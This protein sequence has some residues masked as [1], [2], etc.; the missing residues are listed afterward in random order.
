MQ[1]GTVAGGIFILYHIGRAIFS[2]DKSGGTSQKLLCDGTE[3]TYPGNQY[4]IAA[5]AIEAAIWGTWYLPSWTENDETIG[6]ILMQMQTTD[7]VCALNNAFGTRFRGVIFKDGGNLAQ[8]LQAYLDKSVKNKVNEYYYSRGIQ[9]F[10][11]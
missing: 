4:K 8:T 10:W 2:T 5:D 3:L 11:L 1:A 9:W 7:D 6:A